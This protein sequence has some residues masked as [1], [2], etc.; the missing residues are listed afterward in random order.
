MMSEVTSCFFCCCLFVCLLFVVFAVVMLQTDVVVS[1]LWIP[2]LKVCYQVQEQNISSLFYLVNVTQRE[3]INSAMQHS[4]NAATQSLMGL[5]LPSFA[6][7]GHRI[8]FKY[9]F[10]W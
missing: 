6:Y 10:M 9:I 7:K 4:Y 2:T 3:L 5:T 8:D 1:Q